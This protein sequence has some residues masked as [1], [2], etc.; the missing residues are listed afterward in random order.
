VRDYLRNLRHLWIAFLFASAAFAAEPVAFDPKLL[1]VLPVRPIGPA[2][3]GGRITSLAVVESKPTTM[4]VATASG[5]LWKTVNN[6]TTWQAV[7]DHEATVSLGDVAV[8]PSNPALVWVGTGEANA[9]NS[10]SWGDGVYLSADGGKTWRHQGL[11]ETA[12]IGRIVIHPHDTS[13]IYVAALGHL[14]GPNPE[15]GIYKTIDGGQHWQRILYVNPDT[16]FIDLA[17]DAQ[18]PATLYAAAYQ[19]RRDGFSGG[20]PAVGTGPG[21]GLYRTT[22]AGKTWVRLRQG[23]P[24][25]PLGRCGLAVDRKNPRVLYAVIQT[26]KTPTTSAGQAAKAS[27]KTETGGIFRSDDRGDTWIKLN[28][29]CPRPFYYGQVRIDPND[30]RRLY[31]LGIALHVSGDGGKT[32]KNDGARRAHSDHHALWIDPRDSDHLVL[33]G[34]G[35]LYFSYDRGTTWEHVNNLPIG[36][37]YAISVDMRRPYW[38]YG[39]LQDNGSWGGPSATRTGEGIVNANWR[40]ILGADGFYCQVD[41][42]NADVIYAET[43]FGNPKRINTQTGKVID[44]RPQPPKGAPAYRF[45]WSSPL[46]LSPHN[47]ATIYYGGDHLFRSVDRGSRWE[48]ISPDLTRGKPGPSADFGH[49]ITTIAESPLQPGLLYV[50]TDDGKVQV[51]RNGGAAWRDVSEKLPNVPAG[52]WITR[53]ECSHFADGTAYLTIDRH[54]HNDR[55]P[56]L[57][58]TIDY[59]ATWQP[60]AH[61]LPKEGS[62][63]VVR[64]DPRNASLLFAG[65]EFGLFVTLDAGGHWHR[66]HNGLPTVA[67]HD[68]VIHPRDRELVIATHGRSLYAMDIAPLEELTPQV[69]AEDVHLM[70]VKPAVAFE[71]R[72]GHGNTGARFFAAPNPS[73]GLPIYYYVKSSLT[74]APRITITDAVGKTRAEWTGSQEAGLHQVTWGLRRLVSVKPP[75]FGGLVEP[76]DYT[77]RLA[78]GE[79]EIKKMARVEE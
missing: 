60:L 45:N 56:Y 62:L 28:E 35:G 47:P 27:S 70:N 44:I 67:V 51:S 68:L 23:L 17:M 63:H 4:Y 14:W 2:T 19:V 50:G 20:N 76:G 1:N 18:D 75:R 54:R 53:I 31:V 33:G 36:Q 34:D 48:A 66:I 46:L 10:V 69:L 73:F 21:G 24:D 29:L 59:G 77:V 43:Q 32:F 72:P 30:D 74:E 39:G 5:G 40:Q 79:R 55:A 64:E 52:R 41:P 25:R 42:T 61:D 3:M 16:G 58:K 8:A 49:T 57:C 38:V 9:R 22:D 65:S 26:D 15:R 71:S 6:G 7:F 11:E 78:V 37:F 12:H 13:I